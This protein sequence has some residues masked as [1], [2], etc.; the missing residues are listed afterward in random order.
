[1]ATSDLKSDLI[2]SLSLRLESILPNRSGSNI[3][4]VE[5][6]AQFILT[7]NLFLANLKPT[8]ENGYQD[9][10]P[11]IV[12][13]FTAILEKL[14]ID[15]QTRKLR[16]RDEKTLT[17]TVVV[18]KLFSTIIRFAWDKHA[19]VGKNS[20][21]TAN[22]GMNFNFDLGYH[23]ENYMIYSFQPAELVNADIHHT[24]EVLFCILSEDV[25]RKALANIRRV[26]LDKQKPIDYS[27]AGDIAL[28]QDEVKAYVRDIDEN[29]LI[30]LRYLAAANPNDYYSFLNRKLFAF[31]ERG[32]YI[33]NAALN[34][35]SCLL[36][37][38]YYTK[39]V[40]DQYA[41]QVYSMMPYIRSNSWKQVCLYFDS[42]NIKYQCLHRPRFYAEQVI[43]GQPSEQNF[44]TLFDYVSTAFEDQEYIGIA[45]SLHSWFVILCPSD[46]DELL[47]KP[48][49][50][51]QAF[52]K[53]L[54]FLTSILKDAS[55]GANLEC[56]ESLINI[57]SLGARIPDLKGDVREFSVKYIDET[58][59]NLNKMGANCITD[60][61]KARFR[62]LSIDLYVAA[63]AINPGKY[64]PI[65]VDFFTSSLPKS[66]DGCKDQCLCEEIEICMNVIKGLAHV[67]TYKEPLKVVMDELREPLKSLLFTTY[68]KLNMYDSTRPE[69]S[70]SSSILSAPSD[71]L[72][73]MDKSMANSNPI[74][75]SLKK[76]NLDY[77]LGSV[78]DKSVAVFS[79]TPDSASNRSAQHSS[80]DTPFNP[81]RIGQC[82]RIMTQLFEIFAASPE[83][84]IGYLSNKADS[85]DEQDQKILLEE[86]I[87]FANEMALPIKQAIHFK[88][89]NGN[90]ELFESACTLAMTMVRGKEQSLRDTEIKECLSFLF[91]NL[92]IKAIAEACTVFSLTDPNFKLCFIFLN[93]FLQERD[94]SYKNVTKNRLLQHKCSHSAC[95]SVCEAVEIILLLA[96]C[97]HDVQFFGMAKLTMRWHILE[98]ESGGHPFNCFDNNLAHVFK[99]ILDDDSVFT[100]FVSLH[101]KFRNILMEAPPTNSLY[102]VWLLIYQRWLDIV[103]NSSTLTDASLVFRHYT[104]FL[105][106]TSGCFLNKEFLEDDSK[107]KERALTLISSFFDRAISLLKSNEL[108]VRVVIKDALSNESHPAV[109]HLVC[110]KLMNA[111]IYYVDQGVITSEGVLFMEQMMAIITAM[112]AIKNDGSFVLVSLLPGVCEFLHKFIGM[113]QNPVDLVKL[114]LR[115]CKMCT[116]IEL[117]RERN[118]IAGA[119]KLRSQ[120]AKISIEWLEQAV[121]YD[122]SQEEDETDADDSVL[123]T[124]TTSQSSQTKHSELEFLYIELASEC[125][126]CLEL[127]LQ[128]SLFEMPEGVSEKNLKQSK[129]LIFSNH[130]S[131][132]FKILQKYTS[133]NPSPTMM[134]SKYKI[135][136]ITD[137]VL[138]SISNILQSDTEHGMHF[139]LPLGYHQNKK[140]RSI[141]LN[142]FG[143]MLST[144]KLKS[145]KEA[146]P[147]KLVHEMAEIYEIYG[148]A[149]EVA[150]PA[151]HNLLATSLH[152]LFGYTKK[153]DKLFVTLL[154]DEISSV[155]RSSDIFRRNSTLTRLMSIFAKED[156]LPYLTVVLKP[157][158]QEIIQNSVVFE[159]EKS[160][161]AADI[162]LFIQYL[163]KI[164]DRIV[165]SAKWFPESFQFICS[166]IYKAVGAKFEDAA[167][168]AVGSFVFLR[169]FCPAIVSP[170]SFFD[171]STSNV[172]VKRSLIQ[173]V[174]VI[175]YMANRTLASLKWEGLLERSER[176]GELNKKIFVFLK[177]MSTKPLHGYPF[178]SLTV[179]PYTGL[180]YIH[181]FFY[182]YFVYIK[183]QW[184][185]GDPLVNAANLH[186]RVV[187]WRKLDRIMRDLGRPRPSISLQGTTSYKAVDPS[188]NLGNSQYAEFMAKM[189]VRNMELAIE[190]QVIHSAVFSDGTP[191]VVVNF[192]YIKDIGYDMST[193]V[194]LILEAAS[195]VWDNKFYIVNDFTQFFYMGIIGKNYVSLMRNY[196]PTV[197]FKN[198]ART[199]YYNL[200]R[201]RHL[202]I[203]EDMVAMRLSVNPQTKVYFYSQ[204]DDPEIISSLC[205]SETITSIDKDI[206]VIYN[207]CQ[208]YESSTQKFVPATLKL[209]RKWMQLC[210]ERFEFKPQFAQ[211]DSLAPVE[212]HQLS[213]ITRCEVS[214]NFEDPNE[215]TL[216]LNR[217]NYEVII[218]SPQRLAILRF[219]YFAMLRNSRESN[220]HKKDEDDLR[221]L[222]WFGKLYNIVFHA[223]LERDVEVRASA[224]YLFSSMS[225]YYDVDFGVLPSHA[226]SVAFPSD[227][228]FFVV[229]VSAYLAKHR[230]E[231]TYRFIKAFFN[232]FERL[233]EEHRVSAI[234]YISPWIDNVGNQIFMELENGTEKVAE[235]ARQFCRITAQTMTMLPFLNTY[236][237]RKLFADLRLTSVLLD[238]VISF[239][240]DNKSDESEWEQILS[241]LSP[242]VELCGELMSRIVACIHKTK[243]DDSDIASQSKLLEITVLI[244]ICAAMF[245]NSYVFSSLYLLHVFFFCSLFID[246]PKLEFGPDLQ[247]LT[248]NTV[249][250]FVHRPDLSDLQRDIIETSI[251]YFTSQRARMLFGFTSGDRGKGPDA[252]H[253]FNR[254]AAFDLLC[255]KLKNFMLLVGSSDDRIRWTARW[256]SLAMEIAFSSG[257]LFQRRAITLVGTLARAGISDQAGGRMMKMLVDNKYGEPNTYVHSG[258][259]FARLEEGLA[260][261]SKY[262]PLLIWTLACNTLMSF[263]PLYQTSICCATSIFTKIEHKLDFMSPIVATRPLLEPIIS[264]FEAGVDQ[265]VNEKNFQLHFM[266]HI[267]LGLI[268]SQF[269]HTS[270]QCLKNMVKHKL[271]MN[272]GYPDKV[273]KFEYLLLAFLAMSDTAYT[274]FLKEEFP[275]NEELQCVTKNSL[276]KVV[277]DQIARNSGETQVALIAAA[278]IFDCDCDS[279]FK[280]KFL[281]LYNHLFTTQR[282]FA[283][284]IFHLVKRGLESNMVSSTSIDLITSITNIMVNV[285]RDEEYSEATGEAE[286]SAILDEFEFQRVKTIKCF[287]ADVTENECDMKNMNLLQ[288]LMHRSIS[289]I[290]EGERLEK[291]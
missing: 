247:K 44:R 208:V 198:C 50:L 277:I 197:F 30:V 89:V 103:D 195:Q 37:F 33:P 170:E 72:P 246:S 267:C 105:V 56:F 162:D 95:H 73:E 148:A 61:S 189:S 38:L 191:V 254:A 36:M 288:Q 74:L 213:D 258:I 6:N 165:N 149:A 272:D 63:I 203:I 48:N 92:V 256:S 24:L 260:P 120:Y 223:L 229:S 134:R 53:R 210:F 211:T 290:V 141:F 91:S 70:S 219:L 127:Q 151:E 275:D 128:D 285:I 124:P 217:Y 262:L 266:V 230:P 135:Q 111:A 121:F 192:R 41:K 270:V 88:S 181:K 171:L 200:P 51:K 49:K 231:N 153:L 122:S 236:V 283:L 248:I 2:R 238:E 286:L 29:I 187:M 106:S 140:I 241:V 202:N 240:I 161:E 263:P 276:P 68:K 19:L 257:S 25:N 250:S 154:T 16:E 11:D 96:L 4:E 179:K 237:W 131:L 289:S 86:L 109:F 159:V 175:Q 77:G 244:K 20:T 182:T 232:N 107:E 137:N 31:A 158:I 76:N 60:T 45:P 90:S 166:E 190:S 227:T 118:G 82:E 225:A 233:P 145:A 80:C 32:E 216:F 67:E 58:F 188:A 57:F 110:T 39:E 87:S 235:I 264:D 55:A 193:F 291:S 54:K 112:T 215:F 228:T 85:L 164:V 249:Q 196:A 274:Q 221:E 284:K 143:D 46:F 123:A 18:M 226:S 23:S 28:S 255:D 40:A 21:L 102:H 136:G 132:F 17:S 206:R 234:M 1:M 119:Y 185:L 108:V 8:E 186:E 99:K 75:S 242:S 94:S 180:R 259:C 42:H 114:K 62:Q 97:T 5:L 13:H 150:S 204:M 271:L 167:L 117:D 101:K 15:P 279:S 84:Y 152:G 243:S 155:A 176:L 281:R 168:V 93:K 3:A 174:K 199:Y 130:F 126:K 116:A 43:P 47:Q 78:K 22:D 177:D 261:D 212:V 245:F 183:H 115:F 205:L 163:A 184:C 139:V 14:N 160:H 273:L 138:K 222:H 253:L 157:V 169:F 214:N 98:I 142:I 201:F 144:K 69:S 125:S 173:L 104:G 172:K 12:E 34:K 71:K 65:L 133:P 178:H 280:L 156:G 269:R 147:D 287:K 27:L 35:Y 194:Y 268:T 129:D 209:G 282:D 113:V 52:N 265:T 252:T 239:A 146:F 10:M 207:D 64:I 278:Y 251:E 59:D 9:F 218:S 220:V 66:E 224:S 81:K 7:T 79:D 26:R 100:G 83:A